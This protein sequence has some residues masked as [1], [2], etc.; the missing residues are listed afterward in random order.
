MQ[1]F[2]NKIKFLA[3]KVKSDHLQAE[4]L[5]GHLEDNLSIAKWLQTWKH[6]LSIYLKW[7]VKKI[8]PLNYRMD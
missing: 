5:L 2:Q 4:L 7:R 3:G 1:F 6:R 8:L